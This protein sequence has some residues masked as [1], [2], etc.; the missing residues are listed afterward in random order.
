[1][2]LAMSVMKA[3]LPSTSRAIRLDCTNRTHRE[4]LPSS[5]VFGMEGKTTTGTCSSTEIQELEAVNM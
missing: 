2:L 5:A 3:D 4:L 1:M